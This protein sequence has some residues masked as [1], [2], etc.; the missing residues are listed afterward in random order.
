MFLSVVS[1][2][3]CEYSLIS[4]PV[5]L[6]QSAYGTSGWAS[7][8]VAR[9]R[10][11]TTSI[12]TTRQR[13]RRPGR[14]RSRRRPR[15]EPNAARGTAGGADA[16]PRGRQQRRSPRP[17]RRR[18]GG[19]ATCPGHRDHIPDRPAFGRP[20]A[21]ETRLL[22]GGPPSPRTRTARSPEVAPRR[23]ATCALKWTASAGSRHRSRAPPLRNDATPGPLSIGPEPSGHGLTTGR[24]D[25]PALGGFGDGNE[26]FIRVV[27]G[28]DRRGQD[29]GVRGHQT[30]RG[31]VGAWEV[32]RRYFGHHDTPSTL[33]GVSV[34]GYRN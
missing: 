21:G 5:S 11:S 13:T 9:L 7:V 20:P 22:T 24:G 14:W 12:D 26:S 10:R 23:K 32:A 16:H 25:S 30:P 15:R 8:T 29:H 33:F 1:G 31:L 2:E 34:L 17:A 28:P 4:R 18:R 19:R 6:R 3:C 27:R